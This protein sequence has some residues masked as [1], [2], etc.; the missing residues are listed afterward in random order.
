VTDVGID[1]RALFRAAPRLGDLVPFIPLADGIPT[2]VEQLDDRLWVQ[3]DDLTD[4]RYGGNK[5]RKLEHLLA[6]AARRGGP[7]LTAGAIGSHHVVA[8]AVHAQ[9]LGLPVEAVRFPQ[10]ITP[11]VEA[12]RDRATGLGVRFTEAPTSTAMPFG[13]A[14]RWARLAPRGATLVTPGGSTPVGVLGYVGAG[15]ELVTGFDHH[16]WDEP[17]AVVVALGSGG[18]SV[19]LALGMAAGGWRSAEV[20]AVRVADAIVTNTAVL[21]GIEA[22][23]RSLLAIG[24]LRPPAARWRIDGG[25]FGDGYGHPTPAGTEAAARAAELG[26]DSEPTYTAKALAAAF[27]LHDAGR[28]V[29]FL[30]TLAAH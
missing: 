3:R 29:V 26:L 8:T 13:L 14:R 23:V 10:P 30:Q 12:M 9:R 24:G 6:I 11:H 15:L 7:V 19:G 2:P 1:E 4:S 18:S 5:V 17:D 28:R 21:R 25:W 27:A 22:G 16:G 20:V